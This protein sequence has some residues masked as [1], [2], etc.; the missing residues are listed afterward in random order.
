MRDNSTETPASH[1]FCPAL[2]LALP[3]LQLQGFCK[4]WPQRRVNGDNVRSNPRDLLTSSGDHPNYYSK[5][6]KGGGGGIRKMLPPSPFSQGYSDPR[7]LA[8]CLLLC[9]P[10][11]EYFAPRHIHDMLKINARCGEELW[12]HC[13]RTTGF[14]TWKRI[15]NCPKTAKQV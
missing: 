7:F 10:S 8:S 2:T 4:Q 3:H 5:S 12:N 6:E 11:T 9:L 1:R 15:S 13:P 14:W